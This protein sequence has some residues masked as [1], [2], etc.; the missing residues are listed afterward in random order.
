MLAVD[1]RLDAVAEVLVV[2]DDAG[3]VEPASGRSGDVDGVDGALVGMDPPEV[4]QVFAGVGVDGE[5]RGVDAVV[6]GGGVVQPG[7]TV[8]VA[9]RHV[10]RRGVVALVDRDDPR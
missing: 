3:D 1:V 7:M 9:D 10:A 5:R 8:G 2:L 6:D 4:Q